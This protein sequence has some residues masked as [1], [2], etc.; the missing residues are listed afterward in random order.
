MKKK[1]GFFAGSAILAGYIL[2]GAGAP[3]IAVAIGIG[4]G[5]LMTLRATRSA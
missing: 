1:W 3:P 4:C 5:A 2:L